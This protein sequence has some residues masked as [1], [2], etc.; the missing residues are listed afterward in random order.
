MNEELIAR[1]RDRIRRTRRVIG[2]AHNT[3]M[4]RLLQEMVE[5]AE[6]DIRGLESR[7]KIFLPRR[8][9]KPPAAHPSTVCPELHLTALS[10]ALRRNLYRAR[11]I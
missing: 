1:M 2:L 3:E 5:E 8:V 4:I 9:R 6:D 7:L 11:V 10:P